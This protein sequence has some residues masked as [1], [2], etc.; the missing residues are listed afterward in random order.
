MNTKNNLAHVVY[1]CKYHIVILPKYRYKVFTGDVKMPLREEIRKLCMWLKIEIIEG[2]VCK[3]H[4]HLCL[5]IPPKYS[6]SEVIG[7]I[8]VKSAIRM[9]NK[10]PNLKRTYW[11]CNFWSRGYFV[12]TV[13]INEDVIIKYIR[14]QDNFDARES[15]G[16]LF[17]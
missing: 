9:F 1:E 2:K 4:I 13:G 11:G 17:K 10:F 5:S 12:S 7:I 3:D 15:Q 8:K 14:D 6:I 16:R